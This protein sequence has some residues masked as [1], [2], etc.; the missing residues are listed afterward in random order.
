VPVTA[1]VNVTLA[2]TCDGV[3]ELPSTVVVGFCEGSPNAAKWPAWSAAYTAPFA[4]ITLCQCGL[5]AAGR[6]HN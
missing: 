4:T 6:L 2:P 3:A 1:A 5:L